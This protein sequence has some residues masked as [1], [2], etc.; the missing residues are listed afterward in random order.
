MTRTKDK[1]KLCSRVSNIEM[2]HLIPAFVVR[3][4][5]STSVTG[6]IRNTKDPNLTQ[7]EGEKFPLFCSDC[8]GIFS[9]LEKY[10]AEEVFIPYHKGN[11]RISEYDYRLGRFC[12]SQAFRKIVYNDC[13]SDKSR[14]LKPNLMNKLAKARDFLQQYV[15]SGAKNQN[16]YSNHL[17][18]TDLVETWGPGLPSPPEKFNMYI[19]RAI[20]TAIVSSGRGKLFIYNKMCKIILLTFIVPR[21]PRIFEST[22]I[23]GMGSLSRGTGDMTLPTE[24]LRFLI[25]RANLQASFFDRLSE[26]QKKLIEHRF[27][28]NTERIPHSEETKA[29]LADE[30]LHKERNERQ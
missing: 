11:S 1:C 9:R 19:T 18:F 14:A 17:I 5:K 30:K 26:K 8:E 28:S 21:K 24:F 27:L 25:D 20:D 2:S 13:I 6:Y 4:L 23:F 16:E 22:R 3:Y 29:F 7:Q 15:L 10:F 12:A